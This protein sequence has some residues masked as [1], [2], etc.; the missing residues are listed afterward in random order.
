VGSGRGGGGPSAGK[1][2][3]KGRALPGG[4]PKQ[5]KKNK[6]GEKG[7]GPPKAG[8]LGPKNNPFPTDHPKICFKLWPGWERMFVE[9]SPRHFFDPW[10]GVGH[11]GLWETLAFWALGFLKFLG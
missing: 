5:K 6:T 11:G 7:G 10:F 9:K 8:L 1:K 4:P 2:K 3:K